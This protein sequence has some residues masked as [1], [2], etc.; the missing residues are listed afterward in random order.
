MSEAQILKGLL[1]LGLLA[2]F[3]VRAFLPVRRG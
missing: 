2:V 1:A 3:A